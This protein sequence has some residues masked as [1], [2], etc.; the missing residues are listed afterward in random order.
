MWWSIYIL[1]KLVSAGSRRRCLISDLQPDARLPV[2][3]EAW[4]RLTNAP[5]CATRAR[6]S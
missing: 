1:D 4:V 2:D 5:N 3:D 6:W